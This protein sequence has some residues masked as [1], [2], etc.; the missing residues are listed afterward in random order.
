MWLPFLGIEGPLERKRGMK[1]KEGVPAQDGLH[2][3]KG[4]R[5]CWRRKGL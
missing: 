3:R 5:N 2:V 4:D 1:D